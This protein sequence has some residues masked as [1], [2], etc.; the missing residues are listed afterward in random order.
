MIRAFE[1]FAREWPQARAA[2][3]HA[4][5][6][7][8]AITPESP[9]QRIMEQT[10]TPFGALARAILHQQVSIFAGRAIVARLA[11]ACEDT[12]E[13]RLVLRLSDE[14]LRGAGLSRQKVIYLR[15]LAEAAEAGLLERIEELPD[16]AV[17]ERLVRLPGIGTW[18]A[19]M[20]CLFHLERP[21]VFSGEDFGLRE[22]IR[23]LDGSEVQPRPQA[24][25]QRAEVW[26]PYRSIAA[27]VLWDLVRQTREGQRAGRKTPSPPTP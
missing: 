22:G 25:D 1:L 24:A 4:D 16:D 23:I 9:V 21:D 7:L 27:V 14:Q 3:Q 6:R 26:K 20:F 5:P 18:T 10:P 17:I 8:H 15:S 19:K 2:W 11:A 12:L 13:P